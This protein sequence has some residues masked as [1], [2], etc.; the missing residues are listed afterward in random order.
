MLVGDWAVEGSAYADP[1][2]GEKDGPESQSENNEPHS[3]GGRDQ[4]AICTVSM[5]AVAAVRRSS[6]T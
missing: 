2:P 1:R 4:N 6:P 5:Y 3:A